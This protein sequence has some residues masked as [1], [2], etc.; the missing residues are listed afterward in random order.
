[1]TRVV[2]TQ[3]YT[4][5]QYRDREGR[6]LTDTLGEA[7]DEAI[8][9]GLTAWEHS[10][11][12]SEQAVELK[13][14]AD[15]KSLAMPSLYTGSRLHEAETL[16]TELDRIDAL[17]EACGGVGIHLLTTNPDP[18]SWSTEEDKSDAQLRTQAGAL[19][20]LVQRCTAHGVTLAYHVHAPEFRAGAREFHHM[21]LAV[22][23][24]KMCLDT[25][26][27]FQGCGYSNVALQDLMDCYGERTVSLHL[28]QSVGHVWSQTMGDGDLDYTAVFERLTAQGFDGPI[29]LECALADETDVSLGVVEAH[30]VSAQWVHDHFP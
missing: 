4:W 5:H 24:L 26:W 8:E 28:R 11:S 16:D 7:F 20:E 3:M 22:P 27:L 23:E 17:A 29:F 19:A 15:E 14:L 12:T 21:L 18:I 30:R 6:A 1:M 2:G 9:A 13:Q 10:A 25:H